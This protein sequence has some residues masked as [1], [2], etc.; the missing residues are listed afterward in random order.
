[1]NIG[2]DNHIRRSGGRVDVR[3]GV[4]GARRDQGRVGTISG[5][6][7]REGRRGRSALSRTR[8]LHRAKGPWGVRLITWK[9][10]EVRGKAVK[11]SARGSGGEE[12]EGERGG[13]AGGR[14]RAGGRPSFSAESLQ[15]TFELERSAG[16]GRGLSTAAALTLRGARTCCTRVHTKCTPRTAE[17]WTRSTTAGD[18]TGE[19]GPQREGGPQIKAGLHGR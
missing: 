17:V 5:A 18:C 15:R 7:A 12:K 14:A 16:A 4:V 8:L 10:P 1:M 3:D 19:R 13:K 2:I 6:I 11:T 9:G